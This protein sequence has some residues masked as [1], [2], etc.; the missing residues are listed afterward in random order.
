MYTLGVTYTGDHESAVCLLRDDTIV[1]ATEEE[2]LSRFKQDGAYPSLAI[3]AALHEVGITVKDLS[4]VGFSMPRRAT[5]MKY[6]LRAIVTGKMPFNKWYFGSLLK[7][8]LKISTGDKNYKSA[9]STFHVAQ[10]V[11][12]LSHHYCHALS[13][14][15]VSGFSESAVLV[16]DGRGA[17]YATTIW[18]DIDSNLTLIE[19][20]TFP[21]SLGLFYAKITGYL[22]FTPLSDEWKVMGL[23]AYGGPGLSMDEVITVGRDDYWVNG[24]G[25]LG[26]GYFDTS[27]LEKVLGPRRRPEDP[28]TDRHKDIAWAAQ[29]ALERAVL[30]IVRRTVRLS[31]V[32]RL[33]LAGG[34]ALNCKANGLILEEGL[35]DDLFVQPAAGDDG[36]A[37]GAAIAAQQLA[38]GSGVIKPMTHAYLGQQI[39]DDSTRGILES[40]KLRFEQVASASEAAAELLANGKIIGWFQGRAEFG[41]RALGNRSI[42]ADPRNA[43]NRDR[44]NAIVKFREGWRPFAP[45]VLEEHA[46]EYFEGCTSSPFMILTF[47][48]RPQVVDLIPAVVHVDGTARVQT[49]N[50]QANE[51][52]WSLIHAF[53]QRTGI[54]V[55]L[56]TSFNLKGDPIVNSVKEAIETFYTSGLDALVIGNYIV[57][58]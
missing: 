3:E 30:A 41:P 47:R 14:S 15:R 23:A 25:L 28:I 45:S 49:V 20:K 9:M 10:Q 46:A 39:A 26:T 53:G 42:L 21:N 32:K 13:A 51:L 56:N 6:N 58:K 22:G 18:Q 31:G 37:I 29:D 44:V 52:Y 48:V 34:I 40:Y 4:A 24:K 57:K 8:A 11:E 19:G 43:A 5:A 7:D 38:G 36:A 16:L 17:R 54:P 33:S 2:R 50:R 35:V 55:L 12:F 27:A 1:F